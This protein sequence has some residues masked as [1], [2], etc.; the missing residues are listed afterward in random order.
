[1]VG[2]GLEERCGTVNDKA[3]SIAKYSVRP[4]SFQEIP[5]DR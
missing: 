1:M 2:F 4:I 5:W 3:F